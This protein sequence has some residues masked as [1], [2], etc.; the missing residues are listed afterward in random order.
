MSE[1]ESDIRQFTNKILKQSASKLSADGQAYIVGECSGNDKGPNCQSALRAMAEEYGWD[2]TL[3]LFNETIKDEDKYA[4]ADRRY[5]T[6]LLLIK[7]AE[8]GTFELIDH[9]LNTAQKARA[10]RRLNTAKLN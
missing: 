1:R 2:L 6:F 9:L 10:L 4:S 3:I 7:Q 5:F 8:E